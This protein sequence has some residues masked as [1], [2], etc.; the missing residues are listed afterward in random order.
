MTNF[1]LINKDYNQ[2]KY[3]GIHLREEIIYPGINQDALGNWLGRREIYKTT[4]RL[5]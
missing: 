4:I 2:M 1:D 5:T 3:S